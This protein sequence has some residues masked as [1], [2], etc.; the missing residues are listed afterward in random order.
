MLE[1]IFF[2]L[3]NWKG[4]RAMETAVLFR[5][6][7]TNLFIRGTLKT[8]HNTYQVIERPWMNNEQNISCI[9]TGIYKA[10]FLKQSSSGRYRNIY[11]LEGVKNR[12][13]ILIHSGNVVNQSKGC[14]LIGLKRGVLAGKPA[15]INSKAALSMLAAEMSSLDF[16]L[17]IVGKQTVSS[18]E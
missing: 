2:V 3:G 16:V 10:R 12:T 11:H 9:P 4:N 18:T 5:D 17:R 8:K 13:G 14:L 1:E 15:V 6:E 7:V